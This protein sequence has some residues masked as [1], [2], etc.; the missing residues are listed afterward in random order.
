MRDLLTDRETAKLLKIKI[1]TLYKTVDFFD[2][3]DDDEWNLI[4]GEHF[5]YVQRRGELQERRF[6]EEGVEALAKYLE[7]ENEGFLSKVVESLT[8]RKRKRKQLLVSRRI[9]QELIEGDG[10]VD[11]IGHLLFVD[12]KT[13]INIL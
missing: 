6:A 10:L 1:N 3:Y 2:K 12:R 9:T 5:E 11:A 4:E 7:G 8:H 13:S